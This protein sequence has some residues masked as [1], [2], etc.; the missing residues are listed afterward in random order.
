MQKLKREEEESVQLK[1]AF[2]S[3]EAKMNKKQTETF[4]SCLMMIDVN[5]NDG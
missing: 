5:V 3:K 4:L 1:E 2:E